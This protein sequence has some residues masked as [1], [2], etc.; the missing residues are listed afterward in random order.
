MI[1]LTQKYG[2]LGNRLSLM[3]HLIAAAEEYGATLLCPAFLDYADLFPAT[4]KDVW[5]RYPELPGLPDGQ[6]V[7][8]PQW[9]RRLAY[10][11]VHKPSKW[12][13][14]YGRGR[15][16]FQTLQLA[17]DQKYDLGSKDFAKL[18]RSRYPV[19][20]SGWR[21][22]CDPLLEKHADLI[23]NHFRVS[24]SCQ[25]RINELMGTIRIESE[26]VVGIHIRHGDYAHWD[27]GKYYFSTQQYAATMHRVREQ[28]RG[29]EVA[30][31]VCSNE[32]L[33][34]ADFPGLNVHFGIGAMIEDMYALAETDLVV[35]PPSTFS[36]WASFYGQAPLQVMQGPDHH[37]D[38]S[39]VLQRH[40]RH[41]AA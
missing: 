17:D 28:L 19:L 24:P 23:R 33:R 12:L 22:R 15:T 18:A 1:V 27:G 2:Q 32:P 3:A 6:E 38:V 10:K 40:H 4:A 26:L 29:H 13:H 36:G 11:L 30:F 39:A 35:G 34:E 9:Q 7:T 16:P 8:I 20:V 21:F 25:A 14:R 5:C 31:L 41:I 37:I